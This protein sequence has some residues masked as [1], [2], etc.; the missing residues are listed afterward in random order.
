MR[1]SL[2]PKIVF[3]EQLQSVGN[4]R[5]NIGKY[6][7]ATIRGKASKYKLADI[8]QGVRRN[9]GASPIKQAH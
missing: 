3:K 1:D 9:P 4:M 6:T 5:E 2:A 8:T 7:F